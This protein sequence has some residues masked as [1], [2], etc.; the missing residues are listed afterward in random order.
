MVIYSLRYSGAATRLRKYIEADAF[1][2][3]D[4]GWSNAFWEYEMRRCVRFVWNYIV[5][6]G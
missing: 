3:K 1:M 5:F 6:L 2:A 4:G